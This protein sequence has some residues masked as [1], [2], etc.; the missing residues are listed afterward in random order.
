MLIHKLLATLTAS[1]LCGG[2][3]VNTAVFVNEIQH[4]NRDADR[5]EF[6]EIASHA[7]SNLSAWRLVLHNGIATQLKP[8]ALANLTG[9]L[10]DG[11]TTLT[12]IHEIQG[13]GHTSPYVGQNITTR[14]IVTATDSTGLYL[15][16]PVGDGDDA[17]SDAIFVYTGNGHELQP[18]DAVT[19]S[20]AIREY[21]PGGASRSG[22]LSITEFYQPQITLHS[23]GHRLPAPVVIG[24]SGR[25]PP[26][27]II[28]D[29]S[30][31]QF[32]PVNDGI[33]FHE[34]LEAMLVTLE[35]AVAVSPSNRYGEIFALANRGADAS[36]LNARGG[37]TVTSGD[38][39]PERVQIHFDSGV[40]DF[41]ADVNAGD[42][43][44]DV[45]GVVGYAFGNFEIYPTVAFYPKRA[46]FAPELSSLEREGERQV[47]IASYNVL[48][49]DPNDEDGDKDLA[50]GRFKRIARQIVENLNSPTIIALQ[51]VQDSSGSR[52]DG[53]VNADITLQLLV[54]S[55]RAEDGPAY[56][57]IDNPPNNNQ[58]GGQPGGNIRVAYLYDPQR[59]EPREVVRIE[60]S[61]LSDG[62][63]FADSRKPLYVSFEAG[64]RVLHL[65]NNHFSSKGGSTP[66]FG[67][68]QPPVNGSEDQRIAQARVVNGFVATLLDQDPDAGVVV[69]G[70]LNEFQFMPPVVELKGVKQPLLVN[71]TESLAPSERY[72]YNYQGNA[73]ALD[74]ILLNPNLAGHAS[75]DLVHINTD[76]ADAA[77]DHDPAL[78][79]LNLEERAK[80]LRFASYNI[81]FNRANAGDLINDLATPDNTQAR[82]VAEIIQRVRPDVLLLNEFDF[83]ER[84]EAVK[85][86]Q[87]NYLWQS[88]NGTQPIRYRHVYLAPSNTGIASGYDLD[89]NGTV[90]GP[91]DAQ[92]FGN[93]PGQYGML[94]L[95]RYPIDRPHVRTFQNFLWKDMPDSMLPT[96]W[97]GADERAVLR[98]SSKSHWDIP[99]K[100]KG[101]VIHVLASHPTPPVFDGPEDRNGR[102]NHDEIRFWIDYI[103]GKNYMYDDRGC[104]GGLPAG[105]SFVIMGDLN[106]DPN[107]G[108][109]TGEP[110]VKLL[111]SAA[112][113][114]DI[115]PVSVGGAQAS[116]RQGGA[117]ELHLGGAD[118]DTA[119]FADGSTGNLR[120][121]YVLPSRNL[122]M[123]GA[124]VFWPSDLDPL[125]RLVGDYP[126]PASDHRLVWI[127]LKKR[128]PHKRNH[129]KHR[130]D[131]CEGR[132]NGGQ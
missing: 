57:Y 33:D 121:D 55:I 26:S 35:D 76:F 44:G 39:N 27:E 65:I 91:G 90:S 84:G 127:D 92:G 43:L 53:T 79:H 34:T 89:N 86:F 36:G 101:R 32:D 77:S 37:I 85:L 68:V 105:A 25:V 18:G 108:D 70:D 38:F 60:D 49:L 50:D 120:T 116:L 23:R 128:Q 21:I 96:D 131:R 107:D 69:L 41:R 66:L 71:M 124:G 62:D 94:V 114:T 100:V 24:R 20:G 63:A 45:S 87:S 48:N 5:G 15:Q 97:Y 119:D 80:A 102:R 123:L 7:G 129:S 95:S 16:D 28:D 122:E 8:Y 118:F 93:F 126:F 82:A 1:L 54:D 47:T 59:A 83:D 117:N 112:I 130:R 113:N 115:I 75:Y 67:Q 132:F 19:V 46:G 58:D 6:A 42:L 61:D 3:S 81:S 9:T 109:S 111:A 99:I 72:S 64:G 2:V 11:S 110:A 88:Q 103:G 78:L 30:L 56:R 29:D 104:T 14:G 22:N 40:L 17:T 52:D 74:H 31:A 4:D 125:F 98:L 12:P 106:A 13:A 10:G 73:Q 51:E